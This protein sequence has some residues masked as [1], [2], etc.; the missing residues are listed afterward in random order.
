MALLAI[1]GKIEVTKILLTGIQIELGQDGKITEG[2]ATA[3]LY[4]DKLGRMDGLPF[5]FPVP[6]K[7]VNDILEHIA[8]ELDAGFELPLLPFE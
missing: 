4:T 1:T 5:R 7:L 2:V 3:S 6:E 8:Q